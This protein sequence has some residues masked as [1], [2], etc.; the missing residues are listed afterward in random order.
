MV[1]EAMAEEEGS[2]GLLIRGVVVAAA[3]VAL[4]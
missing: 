4:D 2:E 3:L 1:Q